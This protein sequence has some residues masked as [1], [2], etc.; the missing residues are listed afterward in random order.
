MARTAEVSSLQLEAN[1][2]ATL[3]V[4]GAGGWGS[5]SGRRARGSEM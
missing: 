2:L 5:V 1:T 3:V 4:G